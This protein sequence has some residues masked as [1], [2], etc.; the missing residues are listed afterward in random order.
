MPPIRS[1]PVTVVELVQETP[2][3]R[4]LGLDVEGR[5]GHR[6]GQHVRGFHGRH[7]LRWPPTQIPGRRGHDRTKE[8]RA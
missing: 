3:A 7:H 6:A 5:P 2:R 1:K 8:Q 4:T